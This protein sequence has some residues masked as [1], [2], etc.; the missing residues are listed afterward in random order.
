MFSSYRCFFQNTSPGFGQ[1][2]LC[3]RMQQFTQRVIWHPPPTLQLDYTPYWYIKL[4]EMLTFVTANSRD[5][6]Q[7]LRTQPS[8]DVSFPIIYCRMAPSRLYLFASRA[9]LLKQNLL[10]HL[11]C[12]FVIFR[13]FILSPFLSFFLAFYDTI[14][15]L[16]CAVFSCNF[17]D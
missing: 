3:L 12:M 13:I 14:F 2:H 15:I 10:T 6:T 1:H 4:T 11:Q 5:A 7:G 8:A 16:H 17:T 9:Y